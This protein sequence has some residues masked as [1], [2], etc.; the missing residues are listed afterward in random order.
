MLQGFEDNSVMSRTHLRKGAVSNDHT[1]H[2]SR[3]GV[4]R[5]LSLALSLFLSLSLSLSLACSLARSL[6]L[7]RS[8]A[9]SLSPPPQDC[10][11]K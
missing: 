1:T 8:F 9:L 4:P 6:S 2:S 5:S 7:A 3:P 11:T 10:L